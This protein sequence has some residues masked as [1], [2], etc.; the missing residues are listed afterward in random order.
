MRILGT[1][2]Q[3]GAVTIFDS[4]VLAHGHRGVRQPGELHQRVFG[5]QGQRDPAR[6]RQPEAFAP[7]RLPSAAQVRGLLLSLM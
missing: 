3:P 6:Q 5:S 7:I 4:L 1:T 2:P